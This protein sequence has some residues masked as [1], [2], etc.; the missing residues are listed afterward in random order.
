V[1]IGFSATTS[2]ACFCSREEPDDRLVA[3]CG[4][5]HQHFTHAF[6]ANI[7]LPKKFQS[8][9]VSRDKLHKTL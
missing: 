7:I 4:Q 8:Q 6:C 5:F 2:V 1:A 3:A 9:N